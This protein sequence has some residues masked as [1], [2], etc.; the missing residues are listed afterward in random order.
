MSWILVMAGESELVLY[1]YAEWGSSQFV[2]I[3]QAFNTELVQIF[4]KLT[5]FDNQ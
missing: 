1:S 5:K 3:C 2:E 4:K